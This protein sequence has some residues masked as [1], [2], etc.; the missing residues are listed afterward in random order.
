MTEVRWNK[1]ARVVLIPCSRCGSTPELR[2]TPTGW[3]VECPICGH[4]PEMGWDNAEN[5][6]TNWMMRNG[7]DPFE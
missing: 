5:A 3:K 1:R 7:V 6:I 2:F 4:P